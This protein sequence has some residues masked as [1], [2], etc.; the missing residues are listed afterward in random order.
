[1]KNPRDLFASEADAL[2]DL[3]G[4]WR[5]SSLTSEIPDPMLAAAQE[6]FYDWLAHDLRL[7]QGSAERVRAVRRA[8][9][10]ADRM[11][12]K[13]IAV[14]LGVRCAVSPVEPVPSALDRM[15]APLVELAVAAGTGR[16]LWDQECES[17]VDVPADMPSG[18][19]VA[20][21]VAGDS[22][23]P[24]LHS[25]D[26]VLVKLGADVARDT[27]VVA[28]CDDGYVVKRVGRI[29]RQEMELVS[30]NPAF[31]SMRVRREEGT[32]LGTVML[33]WCAH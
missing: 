2:I 24:L 12:A 31:P 27:V 28:R 7:R 10:F 8:H 29:V 21:R 20:L 26:T 5:P 3:V 14:R 30:L 19:Y 17:W 15:Q 9:I 11:F 23:T 18:R 25:G 22:M 4:E 32:V 1:M 16:E 13:T 33:R 6:R